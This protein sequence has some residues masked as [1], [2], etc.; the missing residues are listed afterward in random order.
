MVLVMGFNF[1]KKYK[2]RPRFK[3]EPTAIDRIVDALALVFLLLLLVMVF[4]YYPHLPNLIPTH[5]G[6]NSQADNF[7]S[8]NTILL[9]PALAVFLFVLLQVLNKFLHKF[10]YLVKI[11][12]KNAKKQYRLGT[13]IMRFTNLFV[14]LILY[15]TVNKIIK[16][17]INQKTPV[18]DKWFI[19]V[20]VVISVTGL[21]IALI[22]SLLN[23]KKIK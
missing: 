14:M 4:Q 11:T 6:K 15:Y 17:S 21:L 9:L 3:I 12:P 19:P 1:F 18:I 13:R 2:N 20:I 23:N 16:I 7:G 22:I 8:K 5:F 10:N